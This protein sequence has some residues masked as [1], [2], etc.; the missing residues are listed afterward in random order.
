MSSTLM[1][2]NDERFDAEL[3]A[4]RAAVD[5]VASRPA[6]VDFYSVSAASGV[7][8]S[9]LYRNERLRRIV[10]AARDAQPDPWELIA[11][12]RSE[13][14]ELRKRLAAA[15]AGGKHASRVEYFFVE[16]LEAA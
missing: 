16:L 8:R 7:S 15:E 5:E 3:K 13:N 4:V 11:D 10:E 6:K 9:T 14:A 2:M 12:L 1:R